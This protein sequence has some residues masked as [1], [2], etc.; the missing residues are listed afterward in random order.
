MAR[1]MAR[2]ASALCLTLSLVA[3]P[4]PAAA[5]DEPPAPQPTPAPEEPPPPPPPAAKP[6]I[7]VDAKDELGHDVRS[8]TVYIDDKPVAYE[9]TGKPIEVE[10]GRHTIA[11]QRND[12]PHQRATTMVTLNE[13][14]TDHPVH[15][16]FEPPKPEEQPRIEP[17]ETPL[18]PRI[19][20]G[21]GVLAVATGVV[22]LL[23]RPTMPTNC[24]SE[25]G[26]CTRLSA[27]SEAT[28]NEERDTAGMN[29][30]LLRLGT[31]S[32]LA[33]AGLTAVG[34]LWYVLERPKPR[35][36]MIAPWLREN[37]GGVMLRARF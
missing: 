35:T 26:K 10:P 19:V 7:V 24:D 34:V 27:E 15:F 14:V 1:S 12:G 25:T 11:V 5:Q 32:L 30:G 33:G 23:A 6:S 28:F 29:R 8:V 20:A 16:V 21:V 22:L 37:S 36:A 4:L 17:T 3:L 2:F 13:G 18:A 31:V 9:L